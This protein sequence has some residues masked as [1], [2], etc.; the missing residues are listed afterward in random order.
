MQLI[1]SLHQIR[2]VVTLLLHEHQL[3]K[4]DAHISLLPNIL[5]LSDSV[6]AVG[7]FEEW[8]LR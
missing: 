3:F 6:S 1:L 2:K 4:T 8:P 5:P 7:Y